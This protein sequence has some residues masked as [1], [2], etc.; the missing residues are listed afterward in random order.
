MKNDHSTSL[1]QKLDHLK[2]MKNPR[3]D[4]Q[5]LRILKDKADS[6]KKYLEANICNSWMTPRE[7]KDESLRKHKEEKIPVQIL[8]FSDPEVINFCKLNT[9][10]NKQGRRQC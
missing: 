6:I 4:G 5:D 2:I 8:Q 7:K 10:I 1:K 3:R 9:R